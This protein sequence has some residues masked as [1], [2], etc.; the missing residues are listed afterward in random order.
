MQYV[1]LYKNACKKG[2]N[3]FGFMPNVFIQR[4]IFF[5]KI[6]NQIFIAIQI[7]IKIISIVLNL[8]GIN[9]IL[10][11]WSYSAHKFK[12]SCPLLKRRIQDFE[13]IKKR[14]ILELIL[15][16]LLQIKTHFSI[17]SSIYFW[18]YYSRNANAGEERINSTMVCYKYVT[19]NRYYCIF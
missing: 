11:F 17:S 10:Q 2:F 3:P 9:L 6:F 14:I 1:V 12:S 5:C 15:N 4:K 16:N 7:R 18:F 19:R 13:V 8:C